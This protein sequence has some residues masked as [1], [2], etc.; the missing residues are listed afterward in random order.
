[1][2][3]EIHHRAMEVATCVSWPGCRPIAAVVSGDGECYSCARNGHAASVGI[4]KRV[5]REARN[6]AGVGGGSATSAMVAS[7][8]MRCNTGETLSD[9]S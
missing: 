9:A 1:M 8:A 7:S 6:D 4:V 2:G 5:K 3:R